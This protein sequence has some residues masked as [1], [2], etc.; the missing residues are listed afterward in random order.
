MYAALFGLLWE[1][2]GLREK[3]PFEITVFD[4]MLPQKTVLC[5][6]FLVLLH[7]FENTDF[8]PLSK[9]A[10]A[11]FAIFFLHMPI[12]NIAGYMLRIGGVSVFQSLFLYA[13]TISL[14]FGIGYLLKNTIHDKSRYII[15]W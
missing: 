14:C 11:S 1:R 13:A 8:K 2:Q 5:L 3:S 9:I 4:L 7:R 15:G 6:F 10:D 12:L